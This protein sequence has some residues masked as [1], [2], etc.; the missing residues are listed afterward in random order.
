MDQDTSII[1]RLARIETK[2]DLGLGAANAKQADL[3]RRIR[4]LEGW[5]WS[6]I[7]ASMLT[8]GLAGEVG[9]ALISRSGS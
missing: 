6:M 4:V 5:R 3:E 8:G 9:R 2:L 7:G 1:D